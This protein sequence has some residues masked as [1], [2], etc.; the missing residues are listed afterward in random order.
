VRFRKFSKEEKVS[1]KM[2][3]P[4]VLF[5]MV[6]VIILFAS[7]IIMSFTTEDGAFT[8]NNYTRVFQDELVYKSLK[9]TGVWV[10][11][12]VAGQ[13]F[14]GMLV[15]LLLNQVKKGELLF[16]SVILILP[17]ATLDIVAGVMWKWMYND[18]Y[19]VLNEVLMQIG[20]IDQY[21]SWLATPDMA[22]LAVIIANIWKGFCLTG[23][24]LLAGLQTI[25]QQLYEAAE[26]DGANAVKRFWHITIPQLKPVLLTTLMLGTIW[27][28]NYFP[29]IYTMTGGGPSH[30]TETVVTYIYRLSFRFME[31]NK[32]AALSNI[33]FIIILGI[34]MIFLRQISKDG[35]TA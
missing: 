22:M 6:M 30:G 26:I 14:M 15:A 24:F 1:Y 8:L 9:N 2:I 27:T 17:W 28:I 33:L 19:G 7:N 29:L 21:I 35:D 10:L 25:P 34:S 5:I 31:Y 32:S 12:S 23:M 4:Y 20:I 13:F 18:M 16:R 11:G 3:M